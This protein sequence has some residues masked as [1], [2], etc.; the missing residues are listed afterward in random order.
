MQNNYASFLD[1][2]ATQRQLA[3]RF[4]RPR[5]LL[6][7]V[8]AFIIVMT[9][10][11]VY[12]NA[13]GLWFYRDNFIGPVL[14]GV[15]WS[16]VLAGHALV[17]YRHSAAIHAKRELAVED[18]MRGLIS[19]NGNAVNAA[20]LF[21]MHRALE[22]K[23]EGDGRWSLSLTAFAL[24]N[25]LSWTLS[26]TNIGSSWPFQTTLPFAIMIVGGMLTYMSWQKQREDG[27]ESWFSRLPL[28]HLFAYPVGVIL[29]W[30]LGA[31]RAI[32]YWDA[33]NLIRLWGI[34]LGAHVLLDVVIRPGLR[35][36][37]RLR[38]KVKRPAKRKAAERLVLADDG[39]VVALD[40]V[41]TSA[42]MDDVARPARADSR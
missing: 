29:L 5:L 1:Y 33:D 27:H 39:E 20:S 37:T 28:R 32:N 11:W 38:S 26:A 14:V 34:V 13:W 10:T 23:L 24:V 7:H 19:R 40:E 2:R 9:A 3:A 8:L 17:H 16:L 35:R 18:E 15:V 12:G 22:S 25:A 31:Y 4:A 36:I 42:Y 30:A 21:E 41:D 6:L